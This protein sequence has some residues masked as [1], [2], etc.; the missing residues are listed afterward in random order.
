[1][2]RSSGTINGGHGRPTTKSFIIF[3]VVYLAISATIYFSLSHRFDRLEEDVAAVSAQ[4]QHTE[5]KVSS[6]IRQSAIDNA[7][8]RMQ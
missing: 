2:L 6:A 8:S 4:A 5:Q 3:A 1:M 7:A